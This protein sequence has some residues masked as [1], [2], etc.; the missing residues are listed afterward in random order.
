VIGLG[1][2]VRPKSNLEV[3]KIWLEAFGLRGKEVIHWHLTPE[4]REVVKGN[5]V[6]TKGFGELV[7]D[8]RSAS[9]DA[10]GWVVASG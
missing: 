2:V 1:S 8:S 4:F 6:N 3:T 10:L 5:L 9:G 7:T